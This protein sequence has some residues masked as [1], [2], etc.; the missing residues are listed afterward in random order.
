MIKKYKYKSS[1]QYCDAAKTEYEYELNRNTKLDNKVSI[2]LAFCGVV[3]LLFI[4]YLD[5]RSLWE[6]EAQSQM[7][8]WE[9]IL[10]FL[11]SVFQIACLAFF[12]VFI[13]KLIIILKPRLYL[14][15]DT[16]NLLIEALHEWD[17][18]QAYMYLGIKY[19]EF[20]V[21]NNSVN[22]TRSEE[23]RKS[24]KWIAIA[25]ILYFLNEI[26]KRNFI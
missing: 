22:E 25:A 23:Y 16:E 24:M 10:R 4:D 13:I 14:R 2:T 12:G 8:C 5:V 18:D 20:A 9:C 17:N 15:L 1:E 7:Q 19:S 26:V 6:V 21:Y 11:C 3:L